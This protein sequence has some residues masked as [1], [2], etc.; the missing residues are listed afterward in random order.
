MTSDSVVLTSLAGLL[1]AGVPLEK[2]IQHIGHIDESRLVLRYILEI[3]KHAGAKVASDVELIAQW[4]YQREKSRDRI[5]VAAA[6]PRASARLVL[7]LPLITVLMAQIVGF[8]LV[9][10]VQHRPLLLVSMGI[11]V[12]LLLLA[13]AVSSRMI[14][15][16]LP[17]QTN[18]GL[19]LIGVAL[20]TSSGSNLAKAQRS[21]F[22]LHLQIFNEEPSSRDELAL[23][24]VSN[25]VAKTGAR[26]ADLLRAHAVQQQKAAML[27]SELQIERLSIKL[28]LP[29]GLAVLPAFIFIAILPLMVSMFGSN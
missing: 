10:A 1:R 15:R 3:T 27:E 19:Y 24:E 4:C 26:V 6:A 25:L 9:G 29:L 5:A 21:A 16:V 20:E 13:K 8:D 2:A 7:L 12:L 14:D 17:K 28:M 11:G 22:D 18:V 23:L